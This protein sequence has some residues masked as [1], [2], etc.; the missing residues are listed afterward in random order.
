MIDI[1][2]AGTGGMMPL[3]NRWLTTCYS[4]VQGNGILIDCGE[5]TQIA[6][7][8]ADINT[9]RINTLL[10]TH[11]HADHISGFPGLML[12][13]KNFQKTSPLYVFCPPGGKEIIKNLSCICD[14]LPF[15]IFI[16][17]LPPDRFFSFESPGQKDFVIISAP[18]RHTKKCLAYRLTLNR[19]PVFNPEKA[20]E[21][22]IPLQYWKVL[23]RGEDVEFDG[24]IFTTDMVTDGE[25]NPLTYTYATDTR[26]ND[27]LI[28]LAEKSDLFICEGMYGDDE[29]VEDLRKKGHSNF[30]DA[31]MAAKK[32]DVKELWLTHFSPAMPNPYVYKDSIRKIFQNTK[33]PKDGFKKT[34]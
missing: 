27:N 23:H 6:L 2:L 18:M 13:L 5:G 34:L 14:D 20:K 31:A 8:Q 19:K 29:N 4:E 21:L 28:E 1:C 7:A 12:S 32:A 16:D 26:P 22:N 9:N 17:E 30:I 15:K 11:F 10:I 24:K 33:I 25:R 3:K